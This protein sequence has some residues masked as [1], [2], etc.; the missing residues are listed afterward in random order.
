MEIP[1]VAIRER[2]G[3]LDPISLPGL[4]S[5]TLPGMP[6]RLPSGRAEVTEPGMPRNP[7]PPDCSASNDAAENART[8]VNAIRLIALIWMFEESLSCDKLALAA[9]AS[10]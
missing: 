2:C 5:V 3:T 4:G 9:F 6:R 7:V 10:H 1:A 8:I